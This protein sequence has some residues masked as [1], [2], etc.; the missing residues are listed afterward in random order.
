MYV[1]GFQQV[2]IPV[3]FCP[4]YCKLSALLKKTIIIPLFTRRNIFSPLIGQLHLLENVRTGL[5]SY[6]HRLIVWPN[7]YAIA[8]VR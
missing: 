2:Q 4:P 3:Y 1:I 8:M 7:H 5:L 6:Y